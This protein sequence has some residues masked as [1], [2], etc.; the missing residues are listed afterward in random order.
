MGP[1]AKSLPSRWSTGNVAL[2]IV[3]GSNQVQDAEV[4]PGAP[5]MGCPTIVLLGGLS[6]LW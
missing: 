3:P 6:G 4:R 5:R 1:Q 2:N